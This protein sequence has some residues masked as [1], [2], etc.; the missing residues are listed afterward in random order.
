MKPVI[1]KVRVGDVLLGTKNL[2][3]YLRTCSLIR[4]F[5]VLDRRY[6][7]KIEAGSLL[8]TPNKKDHFTVMVN[9]H[10]K[11]A[12][13][14]ENKN[15]VLMFINPNEEYGSSQEFMN[16]EIFAQWFLRTPGRRPDVKSWPL[17]AHYIW[18]G[19][20]MNA[21]RNPGYKLQC[22]IRTEDLEE[23]PFTQYSVI[24]TDSVDRSTIREAVR[25][26]VKYGVFRNL[27][28]SKK[29]NPH[30]FGGGGIGPDLRQMPQ[31]RKK[32]ETLMRNPR[33]VSKAKKEQSVDFSFLMN[34]QKNVQ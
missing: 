29:R 6:G 17:H 4:Y 13:W 3:S 5:Q 27:P 26:S 8:Y 23:V 12:V 22:H 10:G 1:A 11:F 24:D 14:S 18:G 15:V 25:E 34:V 2:R 20:H 28:D 33:L 19:L 7:P 21:W 9:N 30:L 31:L 16:P 32:L